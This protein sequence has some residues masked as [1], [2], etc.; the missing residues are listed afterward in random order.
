MRY[1]LSAALAIAAAILA[2][3]GP[4]PVLA[5]APAPAV[6]NV[7]VL[8]L[9]AE[10]FPANPLIDRGI[11]DA[12]VEHTEIPIGYYAEYFES[13]ASA[14]LDLD[15][16]FKDYLHRKFAGMRID[17]VIA[18]TD[19]VLRFALAYRAELFPD[20]P[21]VYWGVRVPD[22]AT[23]NAG[24][25]IT[26]VQIGQNYADTLRFAL[27]LQP[28]LRRVF[29]VA[30]N[31]ELAVQAA[32]RRNLEQVPGVTLSY[33]D[34]TSVRDLEKAV[35]AVP[36]GTAIVYVWHGQFQ[37]GEVIYT[38]EVGR[39]VTRASPVP[40]YGSSE[41]MFGA[42]VVGGVVRSSQETGVRVGEL[43]A[44]V[45]G[46]TRAQAIPFGRVELSPVVDWRELQRWHIPASRVPNGTRIM[47]RD[48]TVWQRY[49]F[50]IAGAILLLSAQAVLI[51]ALLVQRAQRI[52][53]VK[54]LRRSYSRVR[55]LGARLLSAQEDERSRIARELHDD[56]SQRLAIL[57]IDLTVLGRFVE[58]EGQAI[59]SQAFANADAIG[60]DIRDLS[61][62]LHPA[63]LRLMALAP[64]IAGLQRELAHP[65]VNILFNHE[66]VPNNLPREVT[67]SLYRVVQ[68]ALHNALKYS[69]AGTITID[70]KGTEGGGLTLAIA[71][72]GVG[73]DTEGAESTGLG[74]TSMQERVD[75]LGGTFAIRSRPGAGTTLDIR[76]PAPPPASDVEVAV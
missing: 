17:V 61:H 32:A 39:R 30:N 54:D 40:V 60:K 25:G 6:K 23:R 19:P 75:A 58:G 21:I 51:G 34:A 47:F 36:T 31:P 45:L 48:P 56:V 10:S 76:V 7:L 14:S 55:D 59:A 33:L 66:A 71:D 46:G 65:D 37:P 5:Q 44:R 1:R 12:L 53:A 11:H 64:A 9:G 18:S 29:V 50:Y 68:E 16:A 42:G 70:L 38:D 67:V 57:K 43:A 3:R 74:L 49:R 22:E 52:Q 72:D 62:R 24:A 27:T 20:A 4:V 35:R 69:K 73:F 13:N 41:L 63:R 15:L 28:E 26:G 8:H 2:A